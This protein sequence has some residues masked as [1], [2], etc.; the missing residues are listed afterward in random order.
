MSGDDEWMGGGMVRTFSSSVSLERTSLTS[1]EA[2]L[3]RG[4]GEVEGVV[5]NE[6]RQLDWGELG[7]ESGDLGRG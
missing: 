3:A 5:F 2:I 7:R 6:A 4:A 1:T